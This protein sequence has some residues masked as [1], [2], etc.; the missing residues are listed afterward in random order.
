MK[1]IRNMSVT[2][3]LALHIGIGCAF[4]GVLLWL[5]LRG[6]SIEN[7]AS[8]FA[9][10]SVTWTL[11]AVAFYFLELSIR[12]I[13][14]WLIMRQVANLRLVEVGTALLIGYAVNALLPARIGEQFRADYCGRQY[15][16]SR[17]TVIGT[18][19]IERFADG[20]S[21]LML[22]AI[23][24]FALRGSDSINLVHSLLGAGIVV[25]LFVGAA[26]A[27][28][29]SRRVAAQLLRYFA[30]F[31]FLTRRFELLSE[32]LRSVRSRQTI[33]VFLIT[34]AVWF[35]DG[36]A[37]WALLQAC[38]VQ[39]GPLEI[40]LVMGVVSLS[41]LLPSP[42]GFLG[43]MQY[44]FVLSLSFFGYSSLQGL[45]A[46]TGNQVFLL[47]SMIVTGLLLLGV[48]HTKRVASDMQLAVERKQANH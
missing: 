21:V 26:I 34:I 4:G 29:G 33:I 31:S 45:M 47:G 15:G 5:A 17:T 37:L 6:V 32:S 10:M 42:P 30:P 27:V 24:S 28:L 25:F 2:A 35:A 11:A 18:I 44:A 20:L 43:T 46:A 36:L 8:A 13:R 1:F 23:G 16:V 9:S 22:L 38:G 19:I 40:C 14:W 7:L 39:L 12:S 41:T 48:S 3:K